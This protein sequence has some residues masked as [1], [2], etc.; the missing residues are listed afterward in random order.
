MAL[1]LVVHGEP[2]TGKTRLFSSYPGR[3]LLLDAEVGARF[4]RNPKIFWNPASEQPPTPDAPAVLYDRESGAWVPRPDGQP[5]DLCVV[6]TRQ[7]SDVS[8]VDQW[9]QSG[10]HPFQAV[11]LDTITEAQK[12]LAEQLNG[13]DQ[14]TQAQWGEML[15]SLEQ[16]LR[17]WRDLLEHPTNPLDFVYVSAHSHWRDDKFRP[18]VRGQ[19]ELSMPGFFDVV[20]YLENYLDPS[21]PTVA[22]R[23]LWI[24]PVSQYVAKDRTDALTQAYGTVITNPSIPDMLRVIDEYQQGA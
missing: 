13:T 18:W 19:A 10:Q 20:G 7:W 3:K 4:L 6:K 17:K 11:G 22:S 1:S 8:L 9:L 24:S 16:L 23:R 15:T 21:T 5:W 14:L 2:G 12:K